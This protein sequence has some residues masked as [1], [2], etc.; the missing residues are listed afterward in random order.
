MNYIRS[1]DKWR[2][3]IEIANNIFYVRQVGV[4][5]RRPPGYRLTQLIFFTSLTF[6]FSIQRHTAKR[7]LYD[8][9]KKRDR[10]ILLD[11][12]DPKYQ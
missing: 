4:G 3:E 6:F 1:T 11:K 8:V 2:R 10:N 9:R 5:T 7:K 12:T